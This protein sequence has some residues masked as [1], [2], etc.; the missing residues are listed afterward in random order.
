MQGF[1]LFSLWPCG[2]DRV[3]FLFKKSLLQGHEDISLCF[4]LNVLKLGSCIRSLIPVRLILYVGQHQFVSLLFVHATWVVGACAF[5]LAFF[6]VLFTSIL[7][8]LNY[9]IFIG[10]LISHLVLPGN[11]LSTSQLFVL[12]S[13]GVP[14]TF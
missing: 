9:S 4:I 5:P 7:N 14:L 6:F 2:P 12:V 11:Y 8:C 3:C 13:S 10:S 1:V